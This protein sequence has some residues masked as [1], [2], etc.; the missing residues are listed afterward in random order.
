MAK[1]KRRV[2]EAIATVTT[3]NKTF[4]TTAAKAG[5]A[6]SIIN[7]GVKFLLNSEQGIWAS[8]LNFL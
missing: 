8:N 6:K 3:S 1:I 2:E 4:D 7:K 5:Q